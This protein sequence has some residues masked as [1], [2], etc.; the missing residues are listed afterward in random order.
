MPVGILKN[1]LGPNSGT[2]NKLLNFQL[3]QD[4]R[5]ILSRAPCNH[6]RDSVARIHPD[7]LR[8]RQSV[9]GMRLSFYAALLRSS[10]TKNHATSP[11]SPK[12]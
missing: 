8:Q 2:Q 7:K 4:L 5:C 1:V 10:P 12:A 3:Y 6:R 11:A 9:L